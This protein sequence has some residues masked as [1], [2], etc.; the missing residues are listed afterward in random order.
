MSSYISTLAC[1]RGLLSMYVCSKK[2]GTIFDQSL[3]VYVLQLLFRT[4][5]RDLCVPNAN[6]DYI[7]PLFRRAHTQLPSSPAAVSPLCGASSLTRP[8]DLQAVIGLLRCRDYLMPVRSLI[9]R[10]FGPTMVKVFKVRPC[11]CHRLCLRKLCAR[12]R[13]LHR[14]CSPTE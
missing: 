9:N 8:S 12:V 2:P 6:E 13:P 5:H 1:L 14:W 3:N 7:A 4:A 10:T 11:T